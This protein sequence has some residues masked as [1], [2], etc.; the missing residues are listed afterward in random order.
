MGETMRN[1]IIFV[2]LLG[3]AAIFTV[4][5]CLIAAGSQAEKKLTEIMR[6]EEEQNEDLSV[7]K[8]CSMH[9]IL[10]CPSSF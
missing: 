9:R 6:K 8:T 4:L 3:A 7:W 5:Y 2:A 10:Y 1:I